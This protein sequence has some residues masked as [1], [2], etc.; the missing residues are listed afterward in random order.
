MQLDALKEYGCDEQNI[1]TDKVSGSKTEWP[2]L[3][4]ALQELQSG[5]TL[6]VW[7]LDRLGRSMTHLA[8]TIEELKGRGVSFKSLC[9]RRIKV[10]NATFNI[11]SMLYWG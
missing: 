9:D 5:D 10:S 11:S 4:E 6:V 3:S 2:G 1:Y 8:H 7:R